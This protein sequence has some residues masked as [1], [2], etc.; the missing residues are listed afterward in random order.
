KDAKVRTGSQA[1]KKSFLD[2]APGSKII[3]IASH[4]IF[5][6]ERPMESYLALSANP[7]RA[8]RLSANEIL[9]VDLSRASLIVLS[10]CDTGRV[11]ISKGDE[12]IGLSRAF[13]HAGTNSLVASLWPLSDESAAVIIEKFYNNI[14]A[15]KSPAKSLGLAIRKVK[16]DSKFAHPFYWAPFEV[17][18]G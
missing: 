5:L 10:A 15:G 16:A 13:L 17:I 2:A 8:G 11:E 14:R 4:G 9:E 7:P 18:G 12:I 6:P 3:H 1:S